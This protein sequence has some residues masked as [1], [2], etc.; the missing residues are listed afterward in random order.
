MKKCRPCLTIFS[1]CKYVSPC[2]LCHIGWMQIMND[3]HQLTNRLYGYCS[4]AG[5]A[6]KM[7]AICAPG[8]DVCWQ[9]YERRYVMAI[10]RMLYDFV[11]GKC[12][13]MVKCVRASFANNWT[14]V[15][16]PRNMLIQITFRSNRLPAFT[17][18]T[19]FLVNCNPLSQNISRWCSD[20]ITLVT[21]SIPELIFFWCGVFV[22]PGK[23][24]IDG[25]AET[26]DDWALESLW[27]ITGVSQRK[28]GLLMHGGP[29]EA[30]DRS[31]PPP[32]AHRVMVAAALALQQWSLVVPMALRCPKTYSHEC[33]YRPWRDRRIFPSTIVSSTAGSMAHQK[34]V[35]VSTI[36]VTKNSLSSE[37]CY[38]FRG[39]YQ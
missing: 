4:F 20:V 24:W 26:A 15:M 29:S 17:R 16:G 9:I 22:R 38:I 7:I 18:M 28:C 30:G 5:D 23:Y 13:Y 34:S 19:A 10:G 25:A 36:S 39:K 2:V 8:N 33:W 31:H 6:S 11:G 3:T 27:T 14:I 35:T 37:I 21:R 12:L 1:I 32:M